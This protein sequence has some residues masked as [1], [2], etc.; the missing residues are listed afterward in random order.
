VKRWYYFALAAVVA[1]GVIYVYSQRDRLGLGSLLGS[2][3]SA[4]ASGISGRTRWHTIERPSDGFK[5][6]L[7][8]EGKDIQVPAYN[9]TGGQEP[10]KMVFANPDGDTTYALSWEDN[11]PVARVSHSP[12]QTLNMARDGML[13]RTQTTLVSESHN[14]Q[15]GNLSLDVLARN[16]G[17]GILNARLIY[18]GNRLYILMAVFPSEEVRRERDVKRFFDSFAASRPAAIPQTVPSASQN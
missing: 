13:A 12:E 16:T 8:A 10:V 2:S 9:E 14:M 7:P 18:A 11:P 6:D 4:Q 17:G 15:Y 3:G 1:V 5:V